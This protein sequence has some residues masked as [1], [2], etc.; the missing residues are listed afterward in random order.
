MVA[1]YP[2]LPPDFRL[3][4]PSRRLRSIRITFAMMFPR[5]YSEARKRVRSLALRSYRRFNVPA[6]DSF[7]SFECSSNISFYIFQ[8]RSKRNSESTFNSF[9]S[10]RDF[11]F[12]N[13][14]KR[15]PRVCVMVSWVFASVT[16]RKVENSAR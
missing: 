14:Q 9:S 10:Y 16:E 1:P 4:V 8:E 6:M 13:E 5:R 7:E 15:L 3:I 12:V 11:R 2:F